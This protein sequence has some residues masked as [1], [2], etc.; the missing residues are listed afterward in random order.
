MR[1]LAAALALLAA[2]PTPGKGGRLPQHVT[3]LYLADLG[4]QLEPC[5]CSLDQRGGLPRVATL[6]SRLRAE[7][8]D[9]WLVGGGDL[10][11]ET[12]A[13]APEARRRE[14]LKAGAV[15]QALRLVRLDAS[16]EGERDLAGGEGFA[17]DSGLPFR[18]GTRLGPIGIGEWGN[19]PEAPVRIAVVHRG[20]TREA[21]PLAAEARRLGIQILLASHRRS[22]FDD[23][24]NRVLLDAPVPVVQVQGRGQSLARIDLWLRGDPSR[25]FAVLRGAAQRDE[26]LEV[27]AERR[28]EYARRRDAAA[29][30]G[31]GELAAALSAKIAE[32]EGRERSLR[33]TPLRSPPADRPS[34]VVSFIPVGPDVPEDRAV[35]AVLTRYYGEVARLNLASARAAGR[36][37]PDPSSGKASYIGLDDVPRG[38]TFACKA[39]HPAAWAFW[40]KTGHAR[41]YATLA[42]RSRQFDLDCVRC[43]VTGWM[44][45]GGACSVAATE[46]RQDV[47]CE[48][49]HGPASL[50][51]VDP[52]GH[53]DAVVPVG[54]CRGCHTPD[55]STGFDE[56]SY[57]RR[58]LGP[59]HGQGG[60]R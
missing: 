57:R 14:M 40:R 29:A 35:R 32:L 16:T 54:R 27:S 41:A 38:G 7:N 33:Q 3:L 2:A 22:L 48:S 25:G 23:D 46:G 24:A 18:R 60:P 34:L 43:H 42:D 19:V 1:N 31:G 58:I 5:G 49:C 21:L 50:H 44:E 37:C 45:P 56:A 53:L 39:C 55:A 52:P 28:R 9:T 10:L 59:G 8:P 4:G 6:L 15:A 26:E 36:P 30:A 17:R 12:E 47:Q 13:L 11:F 51:A 20:G